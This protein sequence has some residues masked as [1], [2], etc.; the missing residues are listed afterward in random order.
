MSAAV[1][2]WACGALSAL[3]LVIG[4]G[5]AIQRTGDRWREYGDHKRATPVMRRKAM[6]ETGYNVQVFLLSLAIVAVAV[7]IL[8][9]TK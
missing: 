5:M 9:T 4:V 7:A 1:Q 8:V 6:R 3:L 2:G